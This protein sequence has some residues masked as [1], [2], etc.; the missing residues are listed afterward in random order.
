MPATALVTQ[1][2]V[3]PTPVALASVE[4]GSSARHTIS[5]RHR[6][7][8]VEVAAQG[9]PLSPSE[10][11]SL[12]ASL[13]AA[14][15]RRRGPAVAVESLGRFRVLRSGEPV[16]P[17][18]W[19]S[20]KARDLL[21]ILV[22]RRGRPVPREVLMEL[23]WPGEPAAKAS[24]RLSVAS[25]TLRSVLDPN[26][27]FEGDHF[28]VGDKE[29]LCLEL[30]HLAVD[31]EAF[32][33]DTAA[34][35]LVGQLGGGEAVERLRRAEA[36]YRGEFLEENPY[37][38]WT[39]GLREELRTTYIRVARALAQE[40]ARAGDH[41]IAVRY[42]LRLLQRDPY[43]E[44]AHLALVSGLS[45]AGRYG[46]AEHYYQQYRSRMEELGVEPVA[47]PAPPRPQ[48]KNRDGEPAGAHVGRTRGA[49]AVTALQL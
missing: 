17:G 13:L 33:A 14:L 31:V 12:V 19:Q 3:A 2:G 25:S 11:E 16:G 4:Q 15:G 48:G 8:L 22:A 10:V 6:D 27:A 46:M 37:D 45:G 41:D 5:A 44:P 32:F 39:V 40:A 43:D 36:M 21:K 9:L 49:E 26:H 42:L 1:L 34:L 28:V 35:A 47:S 24:S 20:K 38:D 30:R 23:L 7:V 18:E 29:V